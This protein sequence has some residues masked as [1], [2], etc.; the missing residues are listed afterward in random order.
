MIAN[1]KTLAQV[2][3]ETEE[4]LASL[5]SKVPELRDAVQGLGAGPFC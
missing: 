1:G 5:M 4:K 3:R 2:E